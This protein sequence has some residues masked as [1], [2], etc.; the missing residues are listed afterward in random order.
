MLCRYITKHTKDKLCNYIH[1][2]YV[3]VII[4]IVIYAYK[5]KCCSQIPNYLSI[6][7]NLYHNHTGR[8]IFWN[9]LK[10]NMSSIVTGMV[11]VAMK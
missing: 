7:Y 11:V 3:S 4:M 8:T 10:E 6:T 5:S 2:V 1:V 9:R